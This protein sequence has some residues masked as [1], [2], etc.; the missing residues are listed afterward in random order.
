MK[1]G[2]PQTSFPSISVGYEISLALHRGKPVL[3]LYSSGD[4]P[5]LL[6]YHKDEKLSCEKYTLE[7]V[8]DIIEEFI[9]YLRG[10][11]DTRFTFFITPKIA[12]YLER[13]AKKERIP[14]SVYLRKLIEKDMKH[15]IKFFT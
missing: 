4:P 12:A 9:N 1:N 15:N 8:K 5:N 6:F 2:L 11:N 10:T 3:V 7:T 14:K 13:I